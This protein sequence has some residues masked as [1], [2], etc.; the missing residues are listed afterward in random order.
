M[1]L[2]AAVLIL[3]FALY[4]GGFNG[5]SLIGVICAITFIAS[6]VTQTTGGRK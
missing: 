3:P 1:M 2:L 6:Q 5:A 4:V